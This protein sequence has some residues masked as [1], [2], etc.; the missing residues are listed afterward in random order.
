MSLHHLTNIVMDICYFKYFS[1]CQTS[2]FSNTLSLLS[3]STD[4]IIQ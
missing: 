3:Q 4:D 1:K 2:V